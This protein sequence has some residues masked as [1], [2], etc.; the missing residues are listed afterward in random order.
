SPFSHAVELMKW[1]RI[2]LQ[3]PLTVGQERIVFVD[4]NVKVGFPASLDGKLRIQSS[5]GTVYLDARVAFPATRLVL[6]DV[7][8]GEIVLMDVSA[9]EGKTVREPV[10]IVYRGTV[11]SAI[12]RG[13]AEGN[14]G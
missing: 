2:P 1:E 5:G 4:K 10:Q 3:V 8:S 11:E 12:R 14:N 7:E 9:A 6:K 13:Q